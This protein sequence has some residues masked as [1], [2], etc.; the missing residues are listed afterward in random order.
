MRTIYFLTVLATLIVTSCNTAR[1]ESY[2][3]T[4]EVNGVSLFYAAEG[5]GKPVILLH[6]NGGSHNDFETTHRELAQA[7]YMSMPS[8]PAAK[9][10]TPACP[11]TITRTWRP[12]YMNS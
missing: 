11:N 2:T 4:I 3:D 1:Y 10:R 8:I 12:M 7:G 9:A 5:A 6:G